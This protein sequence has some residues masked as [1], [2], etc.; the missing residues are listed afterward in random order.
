MSTITHLTD[1]Y[2]NKAKIKS[3]DLR[4]TSSNKIRCI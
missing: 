1:S 2:E 3:L 4:S